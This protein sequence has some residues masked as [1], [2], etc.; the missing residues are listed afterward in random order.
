MELV[1]HGVGR[2]QQ[3]GGRLPPE[4]PEE[5]APEDRVLG[6]MRAFP[7]YEV[8]DA[9]P[10]REIRDRGEREDEPGPEDDGQPEREP[11]PRHCEGA[12]PGGTVP[13]ATKASGRGKPVQVRHGPA[14]VRGDA[15][16]H[17]AT[18]PQGWEGGGGG[19]P[20]P[21]TRRPPRP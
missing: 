2:A 20:S 21:K 7:E 12:Y 14:A 5:E 17:D 11:R 1:R 13:V 9:Q 18:G 19:A 16:R 8:P 3:E 15:L 10:T 6:Q 4:G